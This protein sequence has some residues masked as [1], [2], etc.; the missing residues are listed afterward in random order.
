MRGGGRKIGN[1]KKLQK[2]SNVEIEV[3]TK[4]IL[5]EYSSTMLPRYKHV[6]Y[7]GNHVEILS[8]TYYVNK[9]QGTQGDLARENACWLT[10]CLTHA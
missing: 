9:V 4:Y 8:D 3:Q 6:F 10:I 7:K 1:Q 2:F 5:W